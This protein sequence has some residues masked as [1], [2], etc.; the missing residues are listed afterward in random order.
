[1]TLALS[2]CINTFDDPIAVSALDLC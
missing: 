1:L 2:D